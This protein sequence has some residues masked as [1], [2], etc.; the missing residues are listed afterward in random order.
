MTW[1]VAS[2]CSC[3]K[4]SARIADRQAADFRQGPGGRVARTRRAP[5]RFG[6]AR[7]CARQTLAIAVGTGQRTHVLFQLAELRSALA[8]PVLAQQLRDDPFVLAAI[9]HRRCA[10]TPRERDVLVARTPQPAGVAGPATASLQ[11]VSSSVPVR[12]VRLPF[13]G[14]RQHPGKCDAAIVPDP[15]TPPISRCSLS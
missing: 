13:D 9:F 2:S 11:G 12:Q 5:W 14:A 10:A 3:S 1:P 15:S 4:N 7:A 6:R 8:V